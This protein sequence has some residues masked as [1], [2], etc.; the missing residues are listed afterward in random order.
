M[1]GTKRRMVRDLR[2]PIVEK[3]LTNVRMQLFD[4]TISEGHE[5]PLVYL[6]MRPVSCRIG[7]QGEMKVY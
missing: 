2:K 3:N 7:Y 5:Y 4:F 1:L 6:Y